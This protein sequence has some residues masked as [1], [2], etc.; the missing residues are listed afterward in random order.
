MHFIIH[1]KCLL[2][3]VNIIEYVQSISNLNQI[4]MYILK[5]NSKWRKKAKLMFLEILI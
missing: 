2:I 4:R 5:V 1:W 3:C